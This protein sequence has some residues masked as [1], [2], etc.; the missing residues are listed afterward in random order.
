MENLEI[1]S[2]RT[3]DSAGY[4]RVWAQI[5]MDAV[6]FNM[7]SM[8]ANIRE[9]VKIVAVLKT[10][11]YGHGAVAIMKEME[12]LPYVWGYA[13]A[14]FEEAKELRENGA[15]KPII[16]LGYVLGTERERRAEADHTSRLCFSLLLQGTGPS[17]DQAVLL[18]GGYAE[19]TFR[20]SG[21]R[22]KGNP[23]SYSS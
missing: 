2:C 12:K 19:R 1:S 14:T 3:G 4:D 16:L 11:G 15:Q 23:Y 8:R 13:A 20:G 17:R 5:D 9:D 21:K 22:G 10:N 18:P 7:E 6:L